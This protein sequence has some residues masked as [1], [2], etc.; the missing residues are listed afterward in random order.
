M[1]PYRIERVAENWEKRIVANGFVQHREHS[2]EGNHGPWQ[3]HIAW[4]DT[5]GT[6]ASGTCS[7]L[8]ETGYASVPIDEHNRIKINGRWHDRRHWDH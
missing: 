5:H 3:F 4:F 6:G 2:P 7:V 1:K 8:T